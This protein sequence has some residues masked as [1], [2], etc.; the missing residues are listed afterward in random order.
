[1]NIKG[2]F[3]YDRLQSELKSKENDCSFFEAKVKQLT[4][5]NQELFLEIKQL[6][7]KLNN[8]ET[9]LSEAERQN[10]LK[11]QY[12]MLRGGWVPA[13]GILSDISSKT[14]KLIVVP[15]ECLAKRRGMRE[16]TSQNMGTSSNTV[17]D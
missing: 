2:L 4:K 3:D 10:K 5:D 12:D 7:E 16:E 9:A 15:E 17:E 14:D 1:M 11:W 13:E 8:A 6:E